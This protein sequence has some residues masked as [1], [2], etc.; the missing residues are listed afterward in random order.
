MKKAE[1]KKLES[2]TD[3]LFVPVKD[4]EAVA[5]WGGTEEGMTFNH[6]L[7]KWVRDSTV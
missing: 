7:N 4:E 6:V 5:I 1:I 2:L 3:S